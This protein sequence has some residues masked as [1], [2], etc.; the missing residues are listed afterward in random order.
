M[1]NA[2]LGSVGQPGTDESLLAQLGQMGKLSHQQCEYA[3]RVSRALGES[4]P[5]VLRLLRLVTDMEIA[6]A[7]AAIHQLQ[8]WWPN[9]TQVDSAAL[10]RVPFAFA[11]QHRLLPLGV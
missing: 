2:G 11:R 9:A 6:R 1:M 5:H 10:A 4:T 8:V 3:R 7:Q